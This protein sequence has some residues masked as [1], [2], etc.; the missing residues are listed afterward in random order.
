MGSQLMD[1]GK[2]WMNSEP[3]GGAGLKEKGQEKGNQIP[4]VSATSPA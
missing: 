3:G 1:T 2:G 4:C